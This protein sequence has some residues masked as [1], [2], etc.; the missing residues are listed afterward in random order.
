M[1]AERVKI[2]IKGSEKNMKKYLMAVILISG[3]LSCG[4]RLWAASESQVA[5][6]GASVPNIFSMEF[7][8]DSN[9]LHGAEGVTFTNIDLTSNF[10]YPDG[11][12]SGDGKSDT[13]VVCKT[14]MNT[15]W[16]LKM[17]ASTASNFNLANFKYY[18]GQP[19]NRN[20]GAQADGQLARSPAWYSIPTTMAT[21][22]TSGN[23]DTNNTPFGTLATL[24]FV[25]NPPTG[26][27]VGAAYD[28]TI[29]YTLSATP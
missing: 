8:K 11:R 27:V 3:L 9:V 17:S 4:A 21:I 19:W 5:T 12:S 13:G 23:G 18:I 15:T 24:S 1:T 22:Y 28:I 7:Y 25:I 20:S 2:E 26:L 16:Y 29:S 6:M 14:N 10:I